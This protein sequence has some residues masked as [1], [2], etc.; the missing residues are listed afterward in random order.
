MAERV[1]VKREREIEIEIE[2]VREKV[3]DMV[4]ERE[5]DVSSTV[6][7][8]EGGG[9]PPAICKCRTGPAGYLWAKKW[10]FLCSLVPGSHGPTTK[11][12][13]FQCL[14]VYHVVS[15][16]ERLNRSFRFWTVWIREY[17]LEN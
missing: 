2:I 9:G 11:G 5:R 12:E 3:M 16:R 1:R 7:T 4:E 14:K 13:I 17:S 10:A 15:I 6:S 8:G